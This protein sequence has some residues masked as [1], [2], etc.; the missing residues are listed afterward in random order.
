MARG[1]FI[2]LEGVDGA[3]KSTHLDWL[4][5]H[6]RG[7]G[8]EVVVT[9]EPGGTSL[10]EKLRNL[11][12]SETMHIDTETLLMFAARREHLAKVI[13][14]ALDAEKW[15]ISDRFTDATYAYQ[16]G[17]HKLALDRIKA[18]ED[19]VHKGFQPDL[20][21]M[22][23]LPVD[24]AAIR[25]GNRATLDKFEQQDRDFFERVSR[26]YL[27]RAQ[28]NPARIRIIDASQNVKII[29]KELELII[30]SI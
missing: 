28:E 14:P 3:G 2:T 22:F 5:D 4:A 26:V 21:L 19:W 24:V 29:Q 6:L 27:A 9:R 18:L 17:G 15:V 11:V 23:H 12:L 20:T 10:G 16:G 13:F 25:R 1:K 7:R 8:V 30:S